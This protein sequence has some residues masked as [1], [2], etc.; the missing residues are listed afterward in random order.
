LSRLQKETGAPTFS[1]RRESAPEAEATTKE[2]IF[3]LGKSTSNRD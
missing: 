3:R 1:F 2:N